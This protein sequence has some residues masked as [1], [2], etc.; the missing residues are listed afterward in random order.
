VAGGFTGGFLMTGNLS[1]A[2]DAGLSGLKS[3]AIT[4]TVIGAGYGYYEANKAGLDPWTGKPIKSVVIGRAQKEWVNPIAKDLES[5]TISPA[6]DE[7]F[8]DRKISYREGAD[9]NKN[10]IEGQMKDGVHIIDAGRPPTSIDKKGDFQG[11]S[12]NYDGVEHG[13]ILKNPYDRYYRVRKIRIK[14]LPNGKSYYY[15]KTNLR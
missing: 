2:F 14:V 9:F 5:E 10:W 11:F 4:G 1:D 13:A 12:L 6:W 7:E 8:G 15:Y 3:G